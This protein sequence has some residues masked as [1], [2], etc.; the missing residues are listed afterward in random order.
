[1][2]P[3]RAPHPI[4]PPVFG[5]RRFLSGAVGAAGWAIAAA[6]GACTPVR[7]GEP[8]ASA[9]PSPGSADWW[10]AQRRVGLLNFANWPYYI[11]RHKGSRPSLELFMREK[12]IT[13]NYYRPIRDMQSFYARIRPILES[14]GDTGYDLMVLSNGPELDEMIERGWLIEIDHSLLPSFAA[15]AG[16]LVRDPAWDPGN[17]FTVAWQSGFTG[18]AYR[19]EAVEMLGREPTSVR[20]LWDPRLEHRVGM[21]ADTYELGSFGLLAVGVDPAAS[22][23]DAWR[24]AADALDRQRRVVSPRYYDQGYIGALARGDVWIS[25]AWSGDV[26]QINA[27]GHPEI[28]FVVPDEGAMF[29]TD[30]M[31]IPAMAQHP[32]DAAI[33]MDFVYEP[34]IAAM[35]AAWVWYVSPVPEAKKIVAEDLGEEEV[36]GSP[37]VFPGPDVSAGGRVNDYFVFADPAEFD[38]WV[39]TFRPIV[40]AS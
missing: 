1:V 34:R 4:G 38:E 12:A 29:W 7:R 22:T 13:V 15:H 27:L 11:D 6:A 18:I 33:Y 9:S 10:A 24:T 16:P 3:S 2:C 5:R 40:Y 37:L 8:E 32:V 31:V 19:P 21:M 39:A 35:I 23:A 26:F 28:G 30:S 25:M 17:R 36:A 14:G 20:D